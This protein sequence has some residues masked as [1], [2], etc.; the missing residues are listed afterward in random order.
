MAVVVLQIPRFEHC[1]HELII[2]SLVFLSGF[3]VSR[4][5]LDLYCEILTSQP[6]LGLRIERDNLLMNIRE[7][8][9]KLH[10]TKSYRFCGS[11]RWIKN[12]SR[13]P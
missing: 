11:A 13:D 10:S 9:D 6:L 2:L 3:H 4:D 7:S 5:L 12:I 8:V 1:I